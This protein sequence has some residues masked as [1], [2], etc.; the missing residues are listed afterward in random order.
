MTNAEK[1]LIYSLQ[2]PVAYLKQ[3]AARLDCMLDD[4]TADYF[5]S[6]DPTNKEEALFIIHDFK[7]N[8]ARAGIA[9]DTFCHMLDFINTIAFCLDKAIEQRDAEQAAQG[10]ERNA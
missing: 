10:G 5:E 1:D 6:F 2:E 4:L 7:K 9:L 3:Y 8:A